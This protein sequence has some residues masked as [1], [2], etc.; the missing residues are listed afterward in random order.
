MLSVCFVCGGGR[1][2]VVLLLAV[3]CVACVAFTGHDGGIIAGGVFAAPSCV[4]DISDCDDILPSDCPGL[5]VVMW[6]P[7]K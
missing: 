2:R 6:D 1:G 5:G 7:C 4:C 3:A